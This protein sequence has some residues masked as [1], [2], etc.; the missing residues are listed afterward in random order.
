MLN[1]V[2]YNKMMYRTFTTLF[3]LT[4]LLYSY[5]FMYSAL[6]LNGFAIDSSV[7]RLKKLFSFFSA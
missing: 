4:P 6:S 3:F 2:I 1:Y 7:L 5:M